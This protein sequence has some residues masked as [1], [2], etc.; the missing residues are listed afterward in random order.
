MKTIS[1]RK[2]I[3]IPLVVGAIALIITG[4]V[5]A[6]TSFVIPGQVK[7]V[8]ATCDIKLYS[9]SGLTTELTSL[10]WGDLPAGSGTR[11]R[12]IY[13]KNLGNSDADVVA[14]VQNLPA[15]VTQTEE[16]ETVVPR[17]GSG[18]LTI[19]L[20]ASKTAV[21]GAASPTI[22]I[23]SIPVDNTVPTTPTP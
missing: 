19:T 17:G 1:K 20:M 2:L 9:D 23:T 15:G 16:A 18:S 10:A 6:V 13:I 7:V 14:K 3:F 5:F 12:T 11:L 8:P 4:T 21:L 22:N